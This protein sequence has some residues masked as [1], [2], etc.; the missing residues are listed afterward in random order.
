MN[1]YL[2]DD[3]D[4]YLNRFKNIIKTDTGYKLQP[5]YAENNNHEIIKLTNC[6]DEKCCDIFRRRDDSIYRKN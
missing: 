1:K 2:M 4:F 6:N 5:F 3:R